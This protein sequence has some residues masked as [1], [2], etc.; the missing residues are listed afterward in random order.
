[1]TYSA[2][3]SGKTVRVSLTPA[4]LCS[5][6]SQH[7]VPV[8]VKMELYFSCLIRKRVIFSEARIKPTG[9]LVTDNLYLQF[10]PVMA[11]HCGKDYSGDEPPLTSI[12]HSP[13]YDPL[14]PTG[15]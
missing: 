7:E 1:M 15:S 13:R 3:F 9:A 6:L 8:L 4:A 11:Q 14:S 5:L 10:R 2:S 12:S